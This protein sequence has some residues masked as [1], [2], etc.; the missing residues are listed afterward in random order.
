MHSCLHSGGTATG[1]CK[2][3]VFFGLHFPNQLEKTSSFR[4]NRCQAV[5][6]CLG[7]W[8]FVVVVFF[9]SFLNFKMF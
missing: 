9:F 6:E 8:R 1:L 5:M 2:Q 3:R 4:V 7:S